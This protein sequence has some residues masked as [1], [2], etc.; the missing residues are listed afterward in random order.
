MRLSVFS[1]R[2]D[3]KIAAAEAKASEYKAT[4][5]KQ[6]QIIA[7]EQAAAAAAAAASSSGSGSSSSD[8]SGSS[9]GS[10]SSADPGYS[11]GVSASEFIAYAKT[12]VGYPY[13]WGGTDPHTGADC[14]GYIQYCYAH[15]GISIPRTSYLQ[16]FCGKEVSY[17]NAK[18]GDIICYSGHVALY[19]GNGQILHARG[20]AYGICIT[21]NAKYRTIITIRRVL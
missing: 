17:E 20:A 12:F 15:F 8:S 14:S 13:V 19:L 6:N 2:E 21:D 18:Q 4:I 1:S 16:R 7:Q 5:K 9:S 3:D 10:S 11:S